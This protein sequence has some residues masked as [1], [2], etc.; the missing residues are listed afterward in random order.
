VVFIL[1]LCLVKE[2]EENM[3]WDQWSRN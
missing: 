1:L 3:Y 2:K